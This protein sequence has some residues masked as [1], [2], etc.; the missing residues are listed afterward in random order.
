MWST[1]EKIF[2]TTCA[3]RVLAVVVALNRNENQ[4]NGSP[5]VIPTHN[6]V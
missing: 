1:F 2:T 4:A 6:L 3:V 5:K